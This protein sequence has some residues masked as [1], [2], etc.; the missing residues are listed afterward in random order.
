MNFLPYPSFVQS[1]SLFKWV[2]RAKQSL[3]VISLE[4]PVRPSV[5]DKNQT[6]GNLAQVQPKKARTRKPLPMPKR[7]LNNK[8]SNPWEDRTWMETEVFTAAAKRN[9]REKARGSKYRKS[10][11]SEQT[12]LGTV[13]LLELEKRRI[14]QVVH[15]NWK[16]EASVVYIDRPQWKLC[17][18]STSATDRL[19][20][21]IIST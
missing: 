5:V 2:S 4:I 19:E 21:Q 3:P 10:R 8:Q 16:R 15:W 13:T 6:L 1:L 12:A 18:Y 14:T 20:R 11:K 17:R 9:N 7:W